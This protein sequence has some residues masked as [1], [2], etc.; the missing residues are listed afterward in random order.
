[1]GDNKLNRIGC[2]NMVSEA[3]WHCFVKPTAI[4]SMNVR[5]YRINFD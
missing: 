3:I 4:H 2:Y 1:M 5:K